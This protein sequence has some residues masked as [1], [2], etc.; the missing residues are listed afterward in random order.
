MAWQNNNVCYSQTETFGTT[1]KQLSSFACSEVL[2]SNYSSSPLY[3]YD[4]NNNGNIMYSFVLPPSA[5]ETFRGITDSAQV[6][7]QFIS[8]PGLVSYRTQYFSNFPLN[9]Y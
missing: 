6:S 2:I 7:A 8:T 1:L 4:N 9:V 5:R 3:V